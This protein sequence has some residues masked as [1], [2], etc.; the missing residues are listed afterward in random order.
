MIILPSDEDGLLE[1]TIFQYWHLFSQIE[2]ERFCY[3]QR[4]YLCRGK[5]FQKDF[6]LIL[7]E[8]REQN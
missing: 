6:Y 5:I 2:Q 3:W 8:G 7:Q 1:D 4:R